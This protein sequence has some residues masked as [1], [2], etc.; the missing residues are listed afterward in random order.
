MK[1]DLQGNS[2]LIDIDNSSDL[3]NKEGY[4]TSWYR[5]NEKYKHGTINMFI[6]APFPNPLFIKRV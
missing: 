4:S 3:F 5:F 1:T 6:I 2:A